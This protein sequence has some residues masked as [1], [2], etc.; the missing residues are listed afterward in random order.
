MKITAKIE[1]YLGI[2]EEKVRG[3]KRTRGVR[4][5]ETLL[6]RERGRR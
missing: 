2:K 6:V 1:K 4:S 3:E 5:P